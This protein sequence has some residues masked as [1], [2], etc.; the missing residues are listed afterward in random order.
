MARPVPAGVHAV[1]DGAWRQRDVEQVLVK[2][3][4]AGGRH[5]SDVARAG[6]RV[7]GDLCHGGR[8]G[9]HRPAGLGRQVAGLEAVEVAVAHPVHGPLEAEV[10]HA[11]AAASAIGADV[12]VLCGRRG[13]VERDVVAGRGHRAVGAVGHDVEGPRTRSG[14]PHVGPD[15][16]PLVV[17]DGGHGQR[18]ARVDVHDV[19]VAR[20]G[21]HA[22][23]GEDVGP[24]VDVEPSGVVPH[25]D[26]LAVE[27]HRCHAA[28]G[29]RTQV[30][31]DVVDAATGC[32]VALEELAVSCLLLDRRIAPAA[33]RLGGVQHPTVLAD[34]G[35][36]DH[37]GGRVEVVVVQER[38]PPRHGARRRSR[39]EHHHEK[40]ARQELHLQVLQRE[41]TTHHRRA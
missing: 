1:A 29:P 16:V 41:L 12:E 7:G 9:P 31:V 3:L 30:S 38:V 25:I 40:T 5:A 21:G 37:I 13:A 35:L 20:V 36:P 19:A 11:G 26:A 28:A 33:A 18:R 8:A 15:P 39:Q 32:P 4:P 6:P 24:V 23:V 27:R 34:D 2:A 22:V 14:E 17:A 10:V